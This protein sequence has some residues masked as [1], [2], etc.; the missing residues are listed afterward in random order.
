MKKILIVIA[1]LFSV[2]GKAQDTTYFAH[3]DQFYMQ[4]RQRVTDSSVIR[5]HYYIK[6]PRRRRNDRIY[7]IVTGVIFGGLTAWFWAK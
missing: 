5:Q 4:I 2:N 7:C 6:S 3:R 1:I